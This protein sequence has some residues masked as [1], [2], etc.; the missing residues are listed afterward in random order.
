[1]NVHGINVGQREIHTVEPLLRE[2]NSFE[3]E[4]TIEELER[5][6]SPVIDKI[7]TELIQGGGDTSCSEIHE[8]INSVWNKEEFLQQ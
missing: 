7:P 2:P 3:F 1:L 5:Y 6:T 8:S 4:T